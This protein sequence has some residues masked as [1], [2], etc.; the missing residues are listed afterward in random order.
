M[1]SDQM[2]MQVQKQHGLIFFNKICFYGEL[3][4]ENFLNGWIWSE[5]SVPEEMAGV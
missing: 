3:L 5:Y 2:K 1:P 4:L